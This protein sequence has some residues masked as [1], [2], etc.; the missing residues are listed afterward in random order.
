MIQLDRVEGRRALRA[1]YRIGAQ[2]YRD[3]PHHRSTEDEV[4]RMLVEGPTAFHQHARVMPLLMRSGGR[5]VGRFALIHDR[6][7][8]DFVQVAFFE[9]LPG[10]TGVLDAILLKAR[11]EFPGCQ[12]LVAGLNGH[13]NYGCGFLVS[14][15][16]E[17]PLFGLPYT[18]PYYLDYFAGLRRRPMVSFRFESRHFFELRRKLLPLFDPGELTIRTMDR[19]QFSRDVDIYT[20]L[21]NACF[22]DHPYWSDRTATED[23]EL[24]HPFRFLLRDEHFIVAEERGKPVGFLL[25]YPDFN[26]L[27]HRD[28]ELGVHHLLKYKWRD[29]IDTA[30]LTE[31]A[32]RPD[33]RSKR[34]D[35]ALIL[36]MIRGVEAAGYRYTEGGFI[37]EEN[38]G[39]IALT[40]RYIRRALGRKPEPF[41][42]FCVFEGFLQGDAGEPA[43][44]I[45]P[46]QT[47][48][49]RLESAAELHEGWDRLTD[50][51][52]Q[53]RAFLRLLEQHNPC[54]QRYYELTRGDELLGGAIVYT[55]RLDLFTYSG[56]PSPMKMH[57][58]GVPCSQ[59]SS[60]LL[61]DPESVRKLVDHVLH[62]ENGLLIGLNL[63]TPL[64]LPRVVRGSTL[65]AIVL[66]RRF[67][68]WDD[69]RASLRS[70][71]RRRLRKLE[72]SWSGVSSRRGP[73][74][75]FDDEMYDQYLQVLEHSDAKL[76]TLPASLFRSLPPAFTLTTHRV[77]GALVGWHISL[78]DGE[79][80]HFFMVGMDYTRH[81]ELDAHGNIVLAV[82]REAIADGASIIDLGQTAE[83]SKTR[84]GG[85]PESRYL[86]GYNRHRPVR[87]LLDRFRN[88]IEY[89]ES[90]PE[91][92]V[93]RLDFLPLA[94]EDRAA[95]R[96]PGRFRSMQPGSSPLQT[97]T[98]TSQ[99]RAGQ[100]R[101]VVPKGE[102]RVKQGS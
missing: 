100:A 55:I 60:G 96:D 36:E 18:P 13:L 97:S 1:F 69:Y 83:T 71:Y 95:Q 99:G 93:F 82:L 32:V 37:F 30:R 61:G 73:C 50:S 70:S 68:D 98:E 29:P 92:H 21:N 86:F 79:R 58:V 53:R 80:F 84:A 15:F 74:A 101:A 7:L 67:E 81:R 66:R 85:T 63:E 91:T 35:L 42:R 16:S 77:D 6:K 64:D 33:C 102:T 22:Q 47:V 51:L 5:F 65:P 45:R 38:R 23:Y 12:R 88:L 75:R 31:I 89:T 59:S 40:L 34:V 24:F 57:V 76:E 2:V 41:R 52:F 27:T 90:I 46:P 26:Q 19:E 94:A 56:L 10:Q 8:P 17:P 4:M 78:S 14:G 54:R 49:R 25:W 72:K 62:A 87:A 9:A 11:S 48:I 3:N 43:V 20:D 39:S 28:G 44:E